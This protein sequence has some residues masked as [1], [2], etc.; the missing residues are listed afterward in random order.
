[1]AGVL[2]IEVGETVDFLKELLQQQKAEWLLS[3]HLTAGCLVNVVVAWSEYN[4]LSVT[5]SISYRQLM[6]AC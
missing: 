3:G 1:M 2:K 5:G 6:S 4:R